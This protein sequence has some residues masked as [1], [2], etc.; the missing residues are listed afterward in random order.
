MRSELPKECEAALDYDELLDMLGRVEG[1]A[2]FITLGWGRSSH[3][4]V[5]TLGLVGTLWRVPLDGSNPAFGDEAHFA[6]GSSEALPCGGTLVLTRSRVRA[7]SLRTF[8][9]NGFF[10]FAIDTDAGHVGIADESSGP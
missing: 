1:E 7:A 10:R 8:D 4:Q 2:V 5:Y 3:R 9:G 6:V